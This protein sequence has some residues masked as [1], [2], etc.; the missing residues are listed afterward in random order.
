MTN[1]SPKRFAL[2]AMLLCVT[3][4]G[5]ASAQYKRL[6]YPHSSMM[7]PGAVGRE[8][9][10]RGGPLQGYYQPVELVL[11][12]GAKVSIPVEGKFGKPEETVTVGMLIG[13]AYRVKVTGIP[14]H[15]GEELF[16]TIEVVNRLYPPAGQKTRFPIPIHITREELTLALEGQFVTRVVYLEDPN[17]AMPHAEIPGFQRYFDIGNDLDPLR[18]AD[19][20]GRPMAILRI[21]SRVPDEVISQGFLF[22]APPLVKY[23][24][25]WQKIEPQEVKSL[26]PG[27]GNGARV[28]P[29]A[30]PAPRNQTA[31]TISFEETKAEEE[32]PIRKPLPGFPSNM[33]RFTD[34]EPKE[35]TK[36][37]ETSESNDFVIP[38]R[39]SSED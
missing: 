4:G 37:S 25:P 14:N 15:A 30:P 13:H 8:Q 17:S 24:M 7:M 33:F 28:N 3:F 16:P 23:K 32:Q 34:V 36:P 6:H 22:N 31:S 29:P 1:A 19:E 26:A 35:D 10:A 21:G 18:V 12:D 5:S 20:L 2:L 11:P 39:K 38:T 9:L 27:T